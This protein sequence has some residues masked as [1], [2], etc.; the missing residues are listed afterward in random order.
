MIVVTDVVSIAVTG[1]SHA[2]LPELHLGE[3]VIDKL[4]QLTSLYVKTGL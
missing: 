4:V 2:I 1:A 3:T